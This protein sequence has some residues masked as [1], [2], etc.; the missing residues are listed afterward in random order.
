MFESIR[1]IEHERGVRK[2]NKDCCD[3]KV[4]EIENGY[5]IE[6]QGEGVNEKCKSVFENYCSEENIKKYFEK[7]CE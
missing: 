7:C 3:I 6:I 5:R 2:M 1:T 4:S